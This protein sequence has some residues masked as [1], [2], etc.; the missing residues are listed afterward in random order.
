MGGQL[1]LILQL[2]NVKGAKFFI[3]SQ[4]NDPDIFPTMTENVHAIVINRE[5]TAIQQLSEWGMQMIQGQFPRMKERL[6]LE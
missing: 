4:Q 6:L 3:L 5:A 2:L 1:S